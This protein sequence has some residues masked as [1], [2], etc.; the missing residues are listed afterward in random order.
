MND[1]DI[2]AATTQANYQQGIDKW[3]V[4]FIGIHPTKTVNFQ[5]VVRFL[6][7]NS[8]GRIKLRNGCITHL[9][10][11]LMRT[12]HFN[13]QSSKDW[14]WISYIHHILQS[15]CQGR[16]SAHPHSVLF[17]ISSK[18]PSVT[19][20]APIYTRCPPLSHPSPLCWAV[21]HSPPLNGGR[22]LPVESIST[23]RTHVINSLLLI[24]HPWRQTFTFRMAGLIFL[25]FATNIFN[26]FI[27]LLQVICGG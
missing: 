16:K 17:L 3:L 8:K 12:S 13:F 20:I 27:C 25:L 14:P 5:N 26:A 19:V 11:R 23:C 9:C 18:R 7:E 1:A 6:Q 15:C 10:I 21:N 24:S 2:I 22:L 4:I